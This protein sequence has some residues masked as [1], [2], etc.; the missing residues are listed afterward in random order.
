VPEPYGFTTYVSVG[1]FTI[2]AVCL[3]HF[4]AAEVISQLKWWLAVKR[5][6]NAME[7][8]VKMKE[9]LEIW[10][11]SAKELAKLALAIGIVAVVG[12]A[13]AYTVGWL[14]LTALTYYG[15]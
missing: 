4:I 15:L 5:L 10:V 12:L 8:K 14:M 9:A 6:G 1:C 7:V 2:G 3:L 11:E 13:L